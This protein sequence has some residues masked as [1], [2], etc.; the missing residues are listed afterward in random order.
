M[1]FYT[2]CMRMCSSV[3]QLAKKLIDEEDDDD[4]DDQEDDPEG[5]E[6][7]P[8]AVNGVVHAQ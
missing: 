6:D 5:G 4:N 1:L 3:P 2:R 8:T 7:R